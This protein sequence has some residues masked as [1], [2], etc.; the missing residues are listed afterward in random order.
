MGKGLNA[1]DR[2]QQQL[3]RLNSMQSQVMTERSSAPAQQLSDDLRTSRLRAPRLHVVQ[4]VLNLRRSVWKLLETPETSSSL[5]YT[6]RTGECLVTCCPSASRDESPCR[7]CSVAAVRRLDI[8]WCA[9]IRALLFI[10][11]GVS[12]GG[13]IGRVVGGDTQCTNYPNL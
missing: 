8:I 11:C 3:G 10:T 5:P 1:G 13:F 2:L 12:T 7:C 6:E 4:R 9:R